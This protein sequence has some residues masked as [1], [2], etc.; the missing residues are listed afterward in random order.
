M[1]LLSGHGAPGGVTTHFPTRVRT[2]KNPGV[3][4]LKVPST[5]IICVPPAGPGRQRITTGLPISAWASRYHM[6]VTRSQDEGRGLA[7]TRPVIHWRRAPLTRG[8]PYYARRGVRILDDAE[9][10][11]VATALSN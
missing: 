10:T 6:P 2:T 4:F 11:R 9:L 3:R 1:A 5:S 8:L 7:G